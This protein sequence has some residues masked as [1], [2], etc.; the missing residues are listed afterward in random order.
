MANLF[1]AHLLVLLNLVHQLDDIYLINTYIMKKKSVFLLLFAVVAILTGCTKF[2]G[3]YGH[4]TITINLNGTLKEF[5]KVN[6]LA[7]DKVLGVITPEKPT[8]TV[9]FPINERAILRTEA[10]CDESYTLPQ[11]VTYDIQTLYEL[12]IRNGGETIASESYGYK[13]H[14]Q[15]SIQSDRDIPATYKICH[16][17]L[18]REFTFTKSE[19]K[20]PK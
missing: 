11:V 8:L 16:N 14:Y 1:S 4:A 6:V 3:E 15:S 10:I 19:I 12:E 5:V 18:D 17:D 9:E 20:L 2:K 7:D 13:Y